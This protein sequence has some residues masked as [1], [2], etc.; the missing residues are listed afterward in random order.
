MTVNEWDFDRPV[1]KIAIIGNGGGGKSTLARQLGGALDLPVFSLD[2]YQWQPGWKPTAPEA[3][4]AA[5]ETWLSG[6]GWVIDGW[7]SW[8]LIERRFGEVDLIV[9]TD[10]PLRLHYQWALK[11]QVQ[12]MLGLS[13][14]WPP[15]GCS[16]LSITWLLMKTIRR[17]NRDSLPR[18]TRLT[19]ESPLRSRVI[20]L[21][22]PGEL[23][24]LCTGLTAG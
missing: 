4:S 18:V 10:F 8:D 15:P 5:H 21:R 24:Q 23:R 17:V 6:S 11:R 16:A 13:K 7:G 22:S 12:A 20:E 19:S 14:G 2:D 3:M 1:R 9:V